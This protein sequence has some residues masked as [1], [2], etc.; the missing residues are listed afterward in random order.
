MTHSATLRPIEPSDA[1]RRLLR[2]LRPFKVPFALAVLAM[3]LFAGSNVSFIGMMQPLL[4]ESFVEKN[5][6]E[7]VWIPFAIIGLFIL[8]GASNFGAL[9]GMAYVGRGVVRDLRQDLFDHL[10]TLPVMF[11][12]HNSSGQLLTRLTYHVEQIAE[13]ISTALTA[14]IKE[15][16]TVIGLLGLMLWLEWRLTLFSLAITPVVAI[17]INVVSKRFRGISTRIQGSVGGL[18]HVAEEVIQ[19]Q[20]TMKIY[21]GEAFERGQFL[22][23][24]RHNRSL[25]IKLT[26]TRAMSSGVV[27]IVASFALAAVVYYATTPSMIEAL[28]PG[29]FVSYIGAM[30]SLMNPIKELTRVN[31][32]IQRGIAAA[33]E[34]FG[35]L[36]AEPEAETGDLA[37]ARVQ[38]ALRFEGVSFRYP[39]GDELV[40]QDIDLDVPAG[41]TVAF[42]GRSGAGKSTL[43]S[44]L[45]RFYDPTAGRILLDGNDLRD[46]RRQALRT[47]LAMVDQQVRLFNASVADNIAYGLTPR[48]DDAAIQR[49][50]QD[51]Y[52]WE[53][54]EKLPEGLATQVGSN[55]V[56]LSGGQRQRLAIARALL[57]DAP[58][59]LLDEATSALDTESERY[60]QGALARLM[61]GRTTLVIAHRLSTI[62]DADLIVAMDGG[63]VSE[64][65]THDELLARGGLYAGLHAMQ[66][67]EED[68]SSPAEA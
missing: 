67:R 62:R 8:R 12:D 41:A 47:Q 66:F 61:K 55:G 25:S 19:G 68:A 46:Y 10:L 6:A 33:Q 9:Y 20:R 48:P 24:N 42:V 38:G 35:M 11:Y 5:R 45:P 18:N 58:L 2:Y 1:Y 28:T 14:I 26:A 52:A 29:I 59:L 34:I 64:V 60:I 65:G 16:L 44:L 39:G 23:A 3:A 36:E 57:K 22:S 54:I 49:A 7:V 37:P 63:R 4:D 32:R 53:F 56:L 15:G 13:S 31:E 50:A 40:L 43:L 17:I 30:L 51:A 21:G 27:Q